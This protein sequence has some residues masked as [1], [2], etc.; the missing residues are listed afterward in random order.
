M[1]MAAVQTCE[2]EG[3]SV[4]ATVVDRNGIIQAQLRN[5]MAPPVSLGISFKKSYTAVMFNGRGSQLVIN[6]KSALQSLNEHLAFMAGS[7][8]I[9]AG[10]KL[11]GAIG[12]SGAPSGKTDEACA[13]AGFNAIAEDLE[14][15]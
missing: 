4:S 6:A 1:A 12:V 2:K 15:Q 11:Y 8:P 7:I 14:M 10:G 13:L 3:I 5:T 9:K